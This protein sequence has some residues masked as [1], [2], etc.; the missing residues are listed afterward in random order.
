MNFETKTSSEELYLFHLLLMRNFINVLV[1]CWLS[2]IILPLHPLPSSRPPALFD[3]ES[4]TF[5]R[6]GQSTNQRWSGLPMGPI[7]QSTNQRL[8]VFPWG[9]STNQRLLGLPM[10]PIN[11]SACA[12]LPIPP[13]YLTYLVLSPSETWFRDM[14]VEGEGLSGGCRAWITLERCSQL[15]VFAIG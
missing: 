2:S 5:F 3:D 7:I 1:S 6:W 15:A 10:G 8:L 11:Q 13:D 9:Q 12:G 4:F 14:S